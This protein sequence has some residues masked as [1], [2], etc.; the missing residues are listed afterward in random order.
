MDK[1][2][3]ETCLQFEEV[4]HRKDKKFLN[5][6]NTNLGVYNNKNCKQTTRN[7]SPESKT[8]VIPEIC[9]INELTNPIKETS[10]LIKVN[11]DSRPF[12][13]IKVGNN[14]NNH[15]LP[16]DFQIDFLVDSGAACSL[17]HLEDYSKLELP[18]TAVHQNH[19]H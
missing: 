16:S 5:F 8:R 10:P 12:L 3:W 19:N 7:K 2:Q 1:K 18:Q 9:I 13:R 6:A 15:N 4:H 17:L 14:L 11:S